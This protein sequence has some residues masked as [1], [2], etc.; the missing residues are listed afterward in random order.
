MSQFNYYQV[1]GGEE[2]WKIVPVGDVDQLPKHMFRTILSIDTPPTDSSTKEAIA[3][4]KYSGPLYFD[5]DDASSPASTAKHMKALIEK[6]V[7][8]DVNEDCIEVYASG[9]KGFHLLIDQHVFIEKPAKGY[10]N[11]ATIYKEMAYEVAV[12][13]M[14]FRVYTGRKGR[15]LRCPNVMR[16]NNLYKV[17]ITVEELKYIASLSKEDAEEFYKKLCSAP[18]DLFKVKTAPRAFGLQALFESC[19]KKVEGAVRKVSKQKPVELPDDLPSFEAMLRGEGI[20]ADVG[21]HQLAMQIAITAHARNMTSDELIDAAQGLIQNHESDGDRYNTPDKRRREL[22]RMWDYTEDNPCYGYSPGAIRSLLSHQA[23]DLAGLEA[24]KEEIDEGIAGAGDGAP[25][26]FD[27]AGILLTSAGFSV[28][29]EGGLKKVL[30]LNFAEPTEMISAASGKSTLLQS[31]IVGVDGRDMGTHSLEFDAFNSASALNKLVMP[32]GQIFAGSDAQARGA[33]LRLIEKARKG[34]RR[35]YVL[36]REGVDLVKMPFHCEEAVKHGVL[37]YADRQAVLTSDE[38]EGYEDF[39]LKFAGY[40]N[41][42]GIFQSDMSLSPRLMEIAKDPEKVEELRTTLWHALQCQ[43]ASYIGKL[44][45]WFTACHYRMLFHDVYSQFPLLHVTGAAGAGKTSMLK[46]FANLHYYNAE[47]KM[48]TPS[49][50]IFAVKEAVAASASIPLIIDEYKPHEM[51]PGMHDL[52]KLMFRDAYNCREVSR[53]GG[54]RESSDFKV[55]QVAQL[56][57]PICFVAEAAESEPAVM[58]RV[59][60][61]TLVK[62]SIL[63]EQIYFKH[64]DAARS[65]RQ[66]LGVL[67]AFLAKSM[68]NK[69]SSQSLREEFDPIYTQARKELMLQAD[70]VDTLDFV[71]RKSK[72]STKERTVFNYAVLRFGIMKISKIINAMFEKDENLKRKADIKA[73][74]EEMYAQATSSVTELQSQTIPEWLKVFNTFSIM[75]QSDPYSPHFLRRGRHFTV[76]E[77]SGGPMFEISARECYTKY[78]MFCAATQDKPLFP[79]EQAFIHAISNLPIKYEASTRLNGGIGVM[80][81]DLEALRLQGFIEPAEHKG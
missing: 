44:I 66:Y 29:V 9:G 40:P 51:R 2:K 71:E 72:S 30:A 46:L 36:N 77:S 24:T 26:E 65:K 63:Q 35:V 6:L 67:G 15:M 39:Q 34:G 47:P 73:L 41:P 18:R 37:I 3:A 78:R 43:S 12:P 32:F 62:P 60:L 57:A 75:A 70:E 25:E 38:A 28:P 1:E 76:T 52:Y 42:L 53:G 64:F 49:S 23:P 8:K 79:S 22:A 50:T 68:V 45:G 10:V 58:E 48:I 31:R 16:P 21:F 20:R 80:A 54:S 33:F 61:L 19:K 69:Y 5:L 4:I 74:L 27:H 11:L 17:Q 55:L 81:F 7:S 59:V 56:A 13:S 14:D